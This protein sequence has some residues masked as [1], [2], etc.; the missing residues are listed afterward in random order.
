M[1]QLSRS[2]EGSIDAAELSMLVAEA[3]DVVRN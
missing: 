2:G 3:Y 1:E